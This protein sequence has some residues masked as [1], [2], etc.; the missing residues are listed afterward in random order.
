MPERPAALLFVVVLLAGL[1]PLSST[2]AQ[3]SDGGPTVT[4]TDP[5][6]GATV[7]ATV[8]IRGDA[9]SSNGSV[10]R[11]EVR[12]DDGPWTDASGTENW[13]LEWDTTDHED[14]QHTIQARAHAGGNTSEVATR[15]VTVDNQDQGPTVT[16]ETPKDGAMV[17]GTRTVAGT[18]SDPDGKI[19]QVE[20]RIDDGSWTTAEGTDTWSFSWDT[21][22]TSDGEHTVQARAHAGDATSQPAN[23]TVRVENQQEPPHVTIEAPEDGASVDGTVDVRGQASDPDGDQLTV[24]VRVDDG[25]WQ[26]ASGASSWTF[27]WDTSDVSGGEHTLQARVFD[28]ID[29]AHSDVRNVTVGDTAGSALRVAI[30]APQ[31][32]ATVDGTVEIQGNATDPG[33]DLQAVEV[34]IDRGDWHQADGTTTWNHSWDTTKAEDGSHVIEARALGPDEPGPSTVRI[35]EVANQDEP[36]EKASSNQAPELTVDTPQD[37]AEITGPIVVEGTVEDPDDPEGLLTVEARVDG[38]PWEGTTA[39]SGEPFR[40][41]VDASNLSPGDHQLTIRATDGDNQTAQEERNVT[42]GAAEGSEDQP[43]EASPTLVGA[44]TFLV[45]LL[46]GIGGLYAWSRT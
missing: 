45:L 28:G 8:T 46:L 15:N 12:I 19:D 13:T 20:V 3:T 4:I 34:R 6:E 1:G 24:E 40:L 37:G 25:D 43:R 26:E 22:E 16:I 38:G 32:G 14:G 21:T 36:L 33:G 31:E 9:S 35:I 27:S 29:H 42:T 7:D 17:N 39:R 18:A 11:V 2:A 44:G 5:A 23:V 30:L 10:D 41:P